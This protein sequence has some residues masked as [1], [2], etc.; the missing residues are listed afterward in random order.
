MSGNSL[1]EIIKVCPLSSKGNGRGLKIIPLC[2]ILTIRFCGIP[3]SPLYLQI[4]CVWGCKKSWFM[5]EP[6]QNE[7]SFETSLFTVEFRKEHKYSF[8]WNIY[9]F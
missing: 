2:G 1:A 3:G 9:T 6:V 8:F 5:G 4:L 7:I